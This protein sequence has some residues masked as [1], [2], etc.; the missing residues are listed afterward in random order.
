MRIQELLHKYEVGGGAALVRLGV[1]V[2]AVVSLGILYDVLAFRN[3]STQEG[4]DAAQLARNLAEGKG[5]TT[6]FIRPLSLHLLDQQHS[7]NEP[8]AASAV[9]TNNQSSPHPDLA[10]APFYPA[11]LAAVLKVNPFGEPDLSKEQTF[12]IYLPDLWIAVFNQLLLG[13]AA[14]MTFRIAKRLFDEPVAWVATCVL[15]LTELFWR[16]TISGLSTILLI[17]LFLGLTGVLASLEVAARE[18]TPSGG[19][20]SWLSALAGLLVGVA[21]LTRYSFACLIV[22]L[23]VL[24]LS[25]PSPQRTAL[26]IIAIAACLAVTVPWTV[27]NLQLSG[28]PFRTAGFSVMEGTSVAPEND[29][30]RTLHPV[31]GQINAGEYWSKLVRNTREI[32][33]SDLPRL[34][35]NLVTAF[36]LAG[37]LVPFRNVVLGRVRLFVLLSLVALVSAQ[38]LGRT[39][40][41]T[42]SLDT[43]SENLLVVVAPVI[44]IYG[45]GFFFILRDQLNLEGPAPRALLW[46]AFYLVVGSPLLLLLL[47]EHPSPLVY[48]PYYPPWI[49]QKSHAVREN[50]TIMS[51]IPWAV[52]WYGHRP[53]V[54]LSLKYLDKPTIRLREDFYAVHERH[55]IHALY[56]T[57]KSLKHMD[58]RPIADWAGG[59]SEDTDWE[60]VRKM[61]TDLGQALVDQ[62]VKQADIEKLGAIYSIIEKTWIRGGGQ[63]WESFVLGIFVKREVPTGFPLKTAVGGISPEVFLTESER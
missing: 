57:A 31:V 23:V 39:A 9:R 18:T 43:N 3:L 12:S 63:D 21:A 41:W 5:Y 60:L 35:G 27:R 46:I 6:S 29:L 52:A 20:L 53:S 49:Q 62:K 2:L 19:R 47:G 58:I 45:V 33:T 56:L 7:A 17:V 50:E 55:R 22:P 14:W 32:V 36:F 13:L 24:L 15:L 16:F 25:L 34:G 51:D 10:N 37:L 38:A 8:P 1:V 4:M 30:D 40:L 11:I 44:F 59:Q 28:T 26:A 48:P 42:D 61:V 54:W